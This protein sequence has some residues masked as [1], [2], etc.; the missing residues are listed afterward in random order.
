M[1]LN[2]ID[3]TGKVRVKKSKASVNIFYVLTIVGVV[4]E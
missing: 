3:Y 1:L 2:G 4:Q